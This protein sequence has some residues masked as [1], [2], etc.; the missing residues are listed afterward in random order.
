MKRFLNWHT[1]KSMIFMLSNTLRHSS[2]Q[3]TSEKMANTLFWR[4]CSIKLKTIL[5][6]ISKSEDFQRNKG[7]VPNAWK[8]S[9]RKKMPAPPLNMRLGYLDSLLPPIN[10]EGS[11]FLMKMLS[12]ECSKN[13]WQQKTKLIIVTSWLDLLTH[14]ERPIEN[15]I[16]QAFL[17]RK[18][19]VGQ[20]SNGS[21]FI[22][23]V[24]WIL[25]RRQFR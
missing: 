24:N 14:W 7:W 12:E 6:Q 10:K 4:I 3:S 17:S 18:E 21:I 16:I 22:T 13:W 19:R 11:W 8:K 23:G 5:L 15:T 20:L 2:L 1:L 9:S 25:F